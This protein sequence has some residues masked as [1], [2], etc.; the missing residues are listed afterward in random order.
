LLY[1][2]NRVA[3]GQYDFQFKLFDSFAGS[4]VDGDVNVPDVDV[5]DGYFTVELDFGAVYDGNERWLEIGVRPGEMNDPNIY[6]F[7]EPRQELTATPYAL[8]AKT[9]GGDNDWM[10]SGNDMYSIPTGNV[11]IGVT[12]PSEQLEVD[13]MISA[14]RTGTSGI[15]QVNDKRLSGAAWNLY[16]GALAEGDFSINEQ[17]ALN[18]PRLYIKAGGNV[19]IGTTSPSA[20]LDVVT[21]DV[22]AVRGEATATGLVTNYGGY[23][24]AAGDKGIGVYG[25]A[26]APTGVDS[27]YN[28][29]GYFVCK[30]HM[31]TGVYAESTGM[32][33][34]GVTGINTSTGKGG[35]FSSTSGYGLI[36]GN[37]NVGIGTTM[38]N[39]Q[40][41]VQGA[42]D[43][44]TLVK[45]DQTGSDNYAGWRIDRDD[46]EKWFIGMNHLGDDLIFRRGASTNDM[47]V[48]TLGRVGIGTTSPEASG[49]HVKQYGGAVAIRCQVLQQMPFA[50]AT[51][52]YCDVLTADVGGA[53]IICKVEGDSGTG[54]DANGPTYD[55]CASGPGTDYGSASSIRWKSDI[56]RIDDALGKVLRLRGVYFN[57]DAAHGGRH[58]VGMVAEEVGEVL[59]EIVS[60]EQNGVD[61]TGMDYSRLTPLL[62]EAVKALKTEVDQVRKENADLR[63]RLE[64]LE[65]MPARDFGMQEGGL[66]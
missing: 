16:S 33:G 48:D 3:D 46:T 51:G 39:T 23:F 47:V 43:A 59:P 30:G 29:G 45:I 34:V 66:R 1:D 62:V 56:R 58:D 7:L 40:L 17:A 64:V 12:S 10:V 53:G 24:K 63:N 28:Y 61:A 5:F 52:I 50:T 32:A 6:T 42:S 65:K 22:N 13:G 21:P 57:W 26:N 9:A 44:A 31:G 41:E 60:Y 25:E 35:Y 36:V 18:V 2:A 27:R 4:K 54:I 15:I 49:L 20:K 19:G 37:G 38:P 14:F 55:F 11:G 8:Y